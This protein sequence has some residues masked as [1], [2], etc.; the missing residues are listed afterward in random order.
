MSLRLK[1]GTALHTAAFEEGTT[2]NSLRAL[3]ASTFGISPSAIKFY[4][5]FPPKELVGHST[6]LLVNTGVKSGMQLEVRLCPTEE[7]AHFPAA[8]VEAAEAVISSSGASTTWPCGACTFLNA[9]T[10]DTCEVCGTKQRAET[11][12]MVR[13]V[14]PADN[15]CLFA[16]VGYLVDKHHRMDQAPALRRQVAT[17]I[18]HDPDNF[19][20]GILGMPVKQ[21]QAWIV[22]K[23]HWGG[24]IECAVF[25]LLFKLEVVAIDV[26]S[27]VPM[28]FGE[29]K[30]YS[31]RIYLLYDGI[32]YDAIH[33]RLRGGTI[34]TILP[35]NDHESYTNALK[36]A[37]EL[38]KA[39]EYTDMNSFTLKCLVCAQGLTGEKDARD[40]ASKTGHIN[41]SEYKT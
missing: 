27:G 19:S 3:A 15:S 40:H 20:D 14:V 10:T 9:I 5:G 41:F 34:V 13:H 12:Q 2:W 32:H 28:T 29:G 37:S 4:A 23:D 18:Q 30:G 36:I 33:K 24:A 39:H 25:A 17:F 8:P 26:K 7:S 11:D 38:R 35:S 31:N 22:D 16:S 21:Y 6:E 1:C